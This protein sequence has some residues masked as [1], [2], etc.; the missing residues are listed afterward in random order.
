[1]S[2]DRFDRISPRIGFAYDPFGDGKTS[3]RAGYGIFSDTLRP[4]AL[5]T[6]QTNQPFSYGWTTFGVPL[7]NPFVNN[8]P[9]LQLLLNYVP[10]T[11][12]AA[13]QGRVFYLPMPENSINPNFTTGY[14]Q[15]WNFSVQRNLWKQTVLTVGYLGSKGTHLLLLEEQNPGVYIPGQS[16]TSNINSRRPYSSFTT[17]TMDT[18]SG[19]S[20][21]NALQVTWNRRSTNGFTLLGS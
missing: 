18:A 8:Q 13:R 14:V 6:N 3:I 4:V 2:P 20:N 1:M 9:T 12:A 11:T 19:Y 5:N 21:Y 7:N 10:P 15:Q 16:T 17:I